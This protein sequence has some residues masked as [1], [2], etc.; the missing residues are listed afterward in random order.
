MDRNLGEDRDKP[1][2]EWK[3]FVETAVMEGTVSYPHEPVALPSSPV[4]SND[5]KS[6]KSEENQTGESENVSEET[7]TSITSEQQNN[8]KES[9]CVCMHMRSHCPSEH[10]RLNPIIALQ[11]MILRSMEKQESRLPMSLL[12]TT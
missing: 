4:S 8:G 6:V 3:E 5:S 2:L 12:L 11:M 9:V 7:T 10:A 1:A